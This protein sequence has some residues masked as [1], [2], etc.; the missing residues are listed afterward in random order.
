M[1]KYIIMGRNPLSGSVRISG[2][3]N[4]VLP[5]LAASILAQDGQTIIKDVPRLKDVQ[6]MKE[7]LE[8]LGCEI[9]WS[10]TTMKVD[11]SKVQSIEVSDF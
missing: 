6:V 1:E 3:K 4:A 5:I 8:F 10:G 11:A 9:E 2:S 7:V